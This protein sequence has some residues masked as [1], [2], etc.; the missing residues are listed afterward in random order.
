MKKHL[1]IACIS[2]LSLIVP[3]VLVTAENHKYNK[4]F[5]VITDF[6]LEVF[7]GGKL[8]EKKLLVHLEIWKHNNQFLVSWSYVHI[9]PLHNKKKVFLCARHFGTSEG[10]IENARAD[11]NGFSFRLDYIKGLGLTADVVGEKREG[12]K[13]YS[14]EASVMDFALGT[15]KKTA[16]VWQ[17]TDK[18]FVL[19]YKEVY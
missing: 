19:P 16:E 11:K 5:P 6:K 13:G 10:T 1:L 2:L 18:V 9:E 3:S 12:Q 15:H 7:R 8:S 4:D 14:V 17:S